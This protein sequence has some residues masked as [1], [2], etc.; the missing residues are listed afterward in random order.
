MGS[1]LSACYHPVSEKESSLLTLIKKG[2]ANDCESIHINALL[3]L[4]CFFI[5]ATNS[6]ASAADRHCLLFKEADG[7]VTWHSVTREEIDARIKN[8]KFDVRAAAGEEGGGSAAELV[9]LRLTDMRSESV[10]F[11]MSEVIQNRDFLKGERDNIVWNATAISMV[12]LLSPGEIEQVRLLLKKA[13]GADAHAADNAFSFVTVPLTLVKTGERRRVNLTSVSLTSVE[14]TGRDA[15]RVTSCRVVKSIRYEESDF[16]I[17]KSTSSEFMIYDPSQ[18]TWLIYRD[19]ADDKA[20]ELVDAFLGGEIASIDA[21]SKKVDLSVMI[22]DQKSS[23][24][25]STEN[26]DASK[27]QMLNELSSSNTAHESSYATCRNKTVFKHCLS[28]HVTD[29][30]MENI[31]DLSYPF[32]SAGDCGVCLDSAEDEAGI[33]DWMLSGE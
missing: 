27:L 15:A 5:V 20:R 18:S 21:V 2:Y 3:K 19:V 22:C 10:T 17:L 8:V 4:K 11:S 1:C 14:N 26:M 33:A 24:F 7:S 32:P 30:N 12:L 6:K 16:R 29:R 28:A 9:D 13:R 23:R 25:G 31:I